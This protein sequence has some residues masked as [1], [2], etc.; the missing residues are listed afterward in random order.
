MKTA[1]IIVFF[2]A[3]P[4]LAIAKVKVP[5]L[6][7][8]EWVDTE[9][10]TNVAINLSNSRTF[11]WRLEMDAS[12]SNNVLIALGKDGE[13]TPSEWIY[14]NGTTS[15]SK[16]ANS[17]FRTTNDVIRVNGVEVNET[18]DLENE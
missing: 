8:S 11:S 18:G 13:L 16:F 2:L 7:Q 17:A 4:A 15:I 9:V 5:T 12:S 14:Q 1:A 3:C 10:M 6:P